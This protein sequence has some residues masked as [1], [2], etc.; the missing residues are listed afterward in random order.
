MVRW[1]PG[2]VSGL[3]KKIHKSFMVHRV[4]VFWSVTTHLVRN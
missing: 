4:P 3:Q 2:N 1:M